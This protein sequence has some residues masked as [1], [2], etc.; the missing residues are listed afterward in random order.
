MHLTS[1]EE[2]RRSGVVCTHTRTHEHTDAH[3]GGSRRIWVCVV[4][5]FPCE[6]TERAV[7]AGGTGSIRGVMSRWIET[8][9]K[10][11]SPSA[12]SG[13]AATDAHTHTHTT[14][15]ATAHSGCDHTT[16]VEREVGWAK[17]QSGSGGRNIHVSF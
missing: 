16:N 8:C 4:K 1:H 9:Y 17:A 11:K 13:K 12:Q 5:G 14:T 3:I 6:V 2:R 10:E 7:A 15:T